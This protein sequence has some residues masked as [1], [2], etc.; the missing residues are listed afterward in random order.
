MKT[1]MAAALS[2]LAGCATTAQPRAQHFVG[3]PYEVVAHRGVIAGEVCGNTVE[4]G[5][6]RRGDALELLG[7]GTRRLQV[8]DENGA[9]H[10]VDLTNRTV[11]ERPLVDLWISGDHITGN[12]GSRTVSLT[13]DGDVYRGQYMRPGTS[14]ELR[15]DMSV[16]GR[17]EMLALPN[18]ELGA[19]AP[20]LLSC[21][22]R[23]WNRVPASL[24][25]GPIAVRFGGPLHVETTAAR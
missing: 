7:G 11:G 5:L 13:A 24:V 16:A 10:I 8:R 2:A 19:I 4:Y 14:D 3:D 23:A 12:V 20:G 9:R 17:A 25:E 1:W 18:A 22:R 21:E 15:G 6:Q